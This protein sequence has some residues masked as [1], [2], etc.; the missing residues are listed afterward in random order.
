VTLPRGSWTT[1]VVPDT[2]L[3]DQPT[4][5]LVVGAGLNGLLAAKGALE[6]GLSVRVVEAHSRLGALASGHNTGKVTALQGTQLSRIAEAADE[7]AAIAYG[8]TQVAAVA[9]VRALCEQLAVPFEERAA[10][11]VVQDT[12]EL[13]V[14]VRER[15]LAVAAGMEAELLTA[16]PEAPYAAAGVLVPA[17]VQLNPQQLVEKLAEHVRTLGGQLHLGARVRRILPHTGGSVARL[18]DGRTARARH[19]VVST[20]TPILGRG[21][22]FARVSAQRSYIVA[23]QGPPVETPMLLT[24]DTPSRSVRDVRDEP[25]SLMVGGAGHGVGRAHSEYAGVREICDWAARWFPDHTPLAHWSAQDYQSVD[26]RPIVEGFRSGRGSVVTVTGMNKWGLTNAVDASDTVVAALTGETDLPGGGRGLVREL[27]GR[28][29]VRLAAQ[30]AE[31]AVSEVVGT[32]RAARGLV[33]PGEGRSRSAGFCTH[34]GGT[35]VYNDAED[36]LDC[37]LHGSRFGTDGSVIE[38]YATRRAPSIGA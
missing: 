10:G 1:G 27:A 34:L 16:L 7:S 14:L 17:Q 37:P 29:A 18:V 4:D 35:L 3:D 12:G 25:F 33:V 20:G 6:R 32:C 21:A 9:R 22:Y 19:V 31:V 11:T 30:N 38:G 24:A 5:V 13:D 26:H 2:P 8:R 23:F 36:T 15:D 28:G